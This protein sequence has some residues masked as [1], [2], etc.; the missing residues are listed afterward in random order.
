MKVSEVTAAIV[1][2]YCGISGSDSDTT[3]IL[4]VLM[5]SAKKFIA[6]YTGLSTDDMDN[7]DDLSLAY[8]VLVNDMYS[9]RD[10]TAR[11]DSLNPCVKTILDMRSTNYI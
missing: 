1:K 8:M 3:A 7:F 5:D 4:S 9:N 10:Y 11:N 2:S 6:G